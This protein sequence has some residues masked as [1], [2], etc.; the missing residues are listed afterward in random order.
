MVNATQASHNPPIYADQRIQSVLVVFESWLE[1]AM[2]QEIQ[3][4][5]A[6]HNLV[7]AALTAGVGLATL[8]IH[9]EK[10]AYIFVPLVLMV[11]CSTMFNHVYQRKAAS[12]KKTSKAIV[13]MQKEIISLNG[14]QD[15]SQDLSQFDVYK[16]YK[17]TRCNLK[18]WHL[19]VPSILLYITL[20]AFLVSLFFMDAYG[21]I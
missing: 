9:S 7:F 2:K 15:L 14:F 3:A 16:N 12:W 4:R 5:Q 11:I 10:G 18:L 17:E 8:L 20:S 19:D 21:T 6:R 1:I 13:G